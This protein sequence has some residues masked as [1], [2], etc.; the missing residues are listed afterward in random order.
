MDTL[1]TFKQFDCLSGDTI[2]L[3]TELGFKR[4]TPVQQAVL[5]LFCGN[6]DVSVDAC[7]G[8]GKTL[9]FVLPLVEKIRTLRSHFKK[10]DVSAKGGGTLDRLVWDPNRHV[11]ARGRRNRFIHEGCTRRTILLTKHMY[12]LLLAG[13][14]AP[15][16]RQP[17]APALSDLLSTSIM[18][19]AAW[20][21]CLKSVSIVNTVASVRP[22]WVILMGHSL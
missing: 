8:S 10:Y 1:N 14:E 9:A 2:S 15:T 16:K 3:L 17:K 22:A 4:A 19:T 7:T 6:K 21:L 13:V 18:R 20:A 12:V 5:P 11:C